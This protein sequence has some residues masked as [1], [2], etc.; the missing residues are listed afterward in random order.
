M[1]WRNFWSTVPSSAEKLVRQSAKNE[2][3][4]LNIVCKLLKSKAHD[5]IVVAQRVKGNVVKQTQSSD[6]LVRIQHR[7]WRIW[8]TWCYRN[9]WKPATKTANRAIRLMSISRTTAYSCPASLSAE[10]PGWPT[11]WLYI[12]HSNQFSSNWH[13]ELIMPAHCIVTAQGMYAIQNDPGP[14]RLVVMHLSLRNPESNIWPEFAPGVNTRTYGNYADASHRKES[15]HC[16]LRGVVESIPIRSHSSGTWIGQGVAVNEWPC[17]M[18]HFGHLQLLHASMLKECCRSNNP[19]RALTEYA[20]ARQE[21][22]STLSCQTELFSQTNL[23]LTDQGP[24]QVFGKA[25]WHKQNGEVTADCNRAAQVGFGCH[26]AST[27]QKSKTPRCSKQITAK[28]PA[29]TDQCRI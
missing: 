20:A 7:C 11:T 14:C 1:K 23:C 26:L 13:L 2:V 8:C 25:V 17:C 22:S 18:L 21:F 12:N 15:K 3:L 19:Q 24:S 6:L 29:D 28:A 10:N 4:A 9:I 5:A 16:L 27:K